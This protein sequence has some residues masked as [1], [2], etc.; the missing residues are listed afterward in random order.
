MSS[1]ILYKWKSTVLRN[2]GGA[3]ALGEPSVKSG[4]L[5]SPRSLFDHV[6]SASEASA[7]RTAV[8][9]MDVW[10]REEAVLC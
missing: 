4:S 7:K 5:D 1:S 2:D 6:S 9:A 8:A 10:V 3:D